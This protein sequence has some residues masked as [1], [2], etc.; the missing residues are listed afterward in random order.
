MVLLKYMVIA[1]PDI[2]LGGTF[3]TPNGWLDISVVL[4]FYHVIEYILDE[5]NYFGLLNM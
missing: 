4:F 3:N 2:Y 5:K 1:I